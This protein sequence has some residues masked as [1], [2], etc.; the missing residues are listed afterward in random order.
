M[1]ESTVEKS[2]CAY[3][4]SRG[5]MVVKLNGPG[6]RGIPDRMFLKDGRAMF[7]EFKA[8][9]RKPT[10]LQE[11]WLRDLRAVGCSAWCVD[12][13]ETGIVAIDNFLELP[14]PTDS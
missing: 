1:R 13:K 3:A 7:I 14:N 12:N 4:K 5:C 2:V 10:A 11:K 6:H 8:P 9:G